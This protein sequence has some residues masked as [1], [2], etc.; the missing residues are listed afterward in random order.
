MRKNI[1]FTDALAAVLTYCDNCQGKETVYQFLVNHLV[2]KFE[3]HF[4][5][6]ERLVNLMIQ[7]NYLER[8]DSFFTIL[9]KPAAKAIEWAA[10]K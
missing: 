8:K 6:G 3:I 7:H 2:E 10:A 5:E 1:L 9:V 4:T